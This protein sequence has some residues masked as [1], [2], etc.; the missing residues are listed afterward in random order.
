MIGG[1]DKTGGEKIEKWQIT[2]NLTPAEATLVVKDLNGQI[3]QPIQAN[4]IYELETGIYTYTV[5]ADKYISQ[6]DVRLEVYKETIIDVQLQKELKIVPFADATDEQLEKMLNAHYNGEIDLSTIW[7]VGDTRKIHINAISSGNGNNKS[8]VEQDM[9]FVIL[10]FNHDDLVNQAGTRTKSAVTI[11]CREVL[12]NNGTVEK[13]FY[14]GKKYMT[15]VND[16]WSTTPMRGWLNNYFITALPISLQPLIK[17]VTK[18]N[19]DNHTQNPSLIDTNDR[20]FWLSH[21]EVFGGTDSHFDKYLTLPL[22]GERYE[23]YKN[24]SYIQKYV[25]NNG[26][27]SNKMSDWIGRG[28]LPGT[29][30]TSE[31]TSYLYTG[32]KDSYYGGSV[33]DTVSIGMAPAFCL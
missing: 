19:F 6:E 31:G 5:T 20:V 12:G 33:Y 14:W 13:V 27:K 2:F 8:H 15:N 7:K 21:S 26:D 30:T 24:S 25:N 1:V 11:Q 9:T 17:T 32:F 22:E 16:N 29:S 3:I 23:Y 28:P 10:D 4:N 18:K